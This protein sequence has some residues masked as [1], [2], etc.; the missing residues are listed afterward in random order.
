MKTSTIIQCLAS[1]IQA[2]LNCI[3]AKN[4]EWESRHKDT[5]NR[6]VKNCLPSGSGFDSGCTV[7]LDKSTGDKI[8]IHTSF[9]HMNDGGYYAGWTEHIV[10]VTPAFT[11]IH[12]SV[13]GR[14]Y[15]DIKEYIAETFTYALDDE[16]ESVGGFDIMP[17]RI[18]QAAAAYKAGIASGTID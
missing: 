13:S 3:Q 6:I 9:H 11:G 14:N 18:V 12:I 16:A 5:I 8:I 17:K 10:T 4:T 7:D 2:R 1:S 15:N